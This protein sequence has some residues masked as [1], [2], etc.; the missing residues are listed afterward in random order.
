MTLG[1]SRV[2]AQTMPVAEARKRLASQ[3]KPKRPPRSNDVVE[4]AEPSDV[5]LFE[6]ARRE[7]A[8]MKRFAR[9]ELDRP[10]APPLSAAEMNSSLATSWPDLPT[11]TRL[12]TQEALFRLR[13]LGPAFAEPLKEE[14]RM[15][16]N[17][18]KAWLDFVDGVGL[19]PQM[20]GESF[21]EPGTGPP[22]EQADVDVEAVYDDLK[23]R[24]D[25]LRLFREQFDNWERRA[26]MKSLLP[27]DE[28][29]KERE[30]RKI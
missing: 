6:A 7:V 20:P 4:G 26:A 29:K 27:P 13:I 18:Y 25:Q 12:L 10:P 8:A 19:F 15:R 28:Q 1:Y 9:G 14:S 22:T 5:E 23:R 17:A 11:F 24:R 21:F 30:R 16:R 3:T 2:E